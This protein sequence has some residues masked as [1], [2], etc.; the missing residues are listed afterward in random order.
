MRGS[1]NAGKHPC[2]SK[3]ALPDAHY[4]QSTS[5]ANPVCTGIPPASVP[6]TSKP[7]VTSV[8]DVKY[9]SC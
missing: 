8:I 9:I 2:L 6:H 7:A 1:D 5:M 3:Y 4:K